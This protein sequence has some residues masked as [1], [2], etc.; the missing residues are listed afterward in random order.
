MLQFAHYNLRFRLRQ[1]YLL[2]TMIVGTNRI[3]TMHTRLAK[4]YAKYLPLRLVPFPIEIPKLTETLQWHKYEDLDPGCIWLR[5]VMNE[6]AQQLGQLA[7]GPARAVQ[8]NRQAVT[9][10][11]PRK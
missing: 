9:P 7:I 10:A 6:T 4:L 1:V 5:K 11:V 2:P 3:A 8:K